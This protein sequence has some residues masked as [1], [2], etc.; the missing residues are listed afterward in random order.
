ML[1]TESYR[2]YSRLSHSPTLIH[3][4]DS[5]PPL[6][7]VY[8][9]LWTW[10]VTCHCRLT[11]SIRNEFGAYKDEHWCSWSSNTKSHEFPPFLRHW[12]S[13]VIGHKC[14]IYSSVSPPDNYTQEIVTCSSC[15]V[16]H[17][18]NKKNPIIG[19][20]FYYKTGSRGWMRKAITRMW[21]D[22]WYCNMHVYD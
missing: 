18:K 7:T 1:S 9:T 14:L 12:A 21:C 15:F 8:L 19:W 6:P 3:W 13:A 5:L 10:C 4:S 22:K 16:C 11:H 20:S 17:Q 2:V